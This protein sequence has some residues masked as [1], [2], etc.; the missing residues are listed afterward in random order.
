MI[1][2]VINLYRT[3]EEA[4]T[5]RNSQINTQFIFSGVQL[6]PF[7]AFKY[8]QITDTPEGINL[9]D[10]TV[11]VFSVCGKELGDITDSFM[12][13][14]L[15]NSLNGN[16]QFVWSLTNIQ[17]DF[18]WDLVYLEIT[19]T[20]GETFYSQPLK[21]TELES[22]KTAVLT[23]KERRFDDYQTIGFRV[24]YDDDDLLQEIQLYKEESTKNVRSTVLS[25]NTVEYWRSELMPKYLLTKL[26]QIV[27]VPYFYINFV[28]A[29]LYESPE[30]P[31]KQAQENFS[32]LNFT[33][34]LDNSDIY[35]DEFTVISSGDFSG[36][37]FSGDDFLIN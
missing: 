15:T 32:S 19:Q 11:K 10:W 33:L 35:S 24:W 30:I 29:N 26:K 4:L 25:E 23:Y 28:R 27:A 3:L 20:L 21:I 6:R 31:R 5:F 36:D 14:K 9:E 12:V 7:Q 18:G 34:N 1:S 8:V 22:E 16:P 37:D 13:E 17:Q 2:P